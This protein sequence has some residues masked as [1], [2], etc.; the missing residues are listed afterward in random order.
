MDDPIL[1]FQRVAMETTNQLVARFTYNVFMKHLG[2]IAR[3]QKWVVEN[4]YGYAATVTNLIKLLKRAGISTNSFIKEALPLLLDDYA[5]FDNKT[6]SILKKL[7]K[8]KGNVGWIFK[9]IEIENFEEQF[10]IYGMS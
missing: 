1:G 7:Y 3:H 2:G 9:R 10:I 4:G 6:I 5:N 8:G